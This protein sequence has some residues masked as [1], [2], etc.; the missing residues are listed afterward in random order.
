MFLQK[1]E[2][3]IQIKLRCCIFLIQNVEK[4]WNASKATVNRVVNS[5]YVLLHVSTTLGLGL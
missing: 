1:F 4:L 5:I 3:V 2:K